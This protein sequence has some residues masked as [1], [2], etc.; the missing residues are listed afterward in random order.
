M[1][2]WEIIKWILGGFGA[3]IAWLV[4]NNI[5]QDRK[6]AVI[7]KS[8]QHVGEKVDELKDT[9]NLFLKT[10]MDTLKELAKRNL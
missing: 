10:E 9:L 7:E 3:V 8:V 5:Q 6:L 2:N 1:E 4:M